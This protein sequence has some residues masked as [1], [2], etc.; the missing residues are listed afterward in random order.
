M[1]T[2]P[3]LDFLLKKMNSLKRSLGTKNIS[4]IFLRGNEFSKTILGNKEDITAFSWRMKGSL[5]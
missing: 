2:K 4:W 3:Y 5:E 1:E